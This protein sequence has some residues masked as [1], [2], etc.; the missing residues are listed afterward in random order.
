M[1][2]I[3]IV[4]I[5]TL[6]SLNAAAQKTHHSVEGRVVESFS[7]DNMGGVAVE[8]LNEDSV[9]IDTTMT[10]EIPKEIL[11]QEPTLAYVQGSYSFVV[12]KPGRYIIRVSKDGYETAC[13]DFVIHSKRE[14]HVA[15][16]DI[17][18][19]RSVMS[20]PEVDVVATKIKMVYKGDT[21][22]YNADA[23]RVAEGSML[24]ALIAMLP[25]ASIDANGQISVNGLPIESLLVNG[26]DFF[27]GS[28]KLA[29]Q[30]LP[31]YSVS[32][33]KIYNREGPTSRM[34]GRDMGD[35]DH[36][37]DVRL[38]KEYA[39]GYMANGEAGG[40]TKQ[41]YKLRAFGMRHNKINRTIAFA[42]INNLNDNRR[43]GDN[44]NW[45]SGA[46]PSGVLTTKSAGLSHMHTFGQFSNFIT[47]N[48]YT[49]TDNN[50]T[51]RSD[52]RTFL[53]GGDVMRQ[54]TADNTAMA[55]DFRSMNSFRIEGEGNYIQ[56]RVNASYTKR[57]NTGLA[58]SETGD[59]TSIANTLLNRSAASG[60]TLNINT[61]I[62]G[63]KKLYIDM[64]EL[65]AA[66]AY[67]RTVMDEF[68]LYDMRFGNGQ[69]PSFHNR[70]KD[71]SRHNMST[72]AKLQYNYILGSKTLKPYYN[73]KYRYN[74][75]NNMMY[76]LDLLDYAGSTD[77]GILPSTSDMLA[78][79]IESNNSYNYRER[80]FDHT[81]GLRLEWNFRKKGIGS[82]TLNMPVRWTT[83][84]LKGFRLE[85]LDIHRTATFFEPDFIIAMAKDPNTMFTQIRL[86]YLSETPQMQMMVDCA[87]NS[88]PLFIQ[89]GNPHLKN[90]HHLTASASLRHHWNTKSRID[91]GLSYMLTKNAVAYGFVYNRQDGITTIRPENVNGNW[92]IG[93]NATYSMNIGK[94]T[95]LSNAFS[96]M[97]IHSVDLASAEGSDV[98]DRSSVNNL[99]MANTLK[100]DTEF[101]NGWTMGLNAKVR[102]NN[103]TSERTGFSKVNATDFSFGMNAMINLPW[104]MQLT[105]DINQYFHRGYE[106]S[107][108]NTEE[109]VWNARL[110][111]SV[112]KGRLLFAIEGFDILG[113]L[114]S[115]RCHINSQGRTE[116]WTNTIPRYAMLSVTFNLT[117]K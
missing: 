52:T 86:S 25:G 46:L 53:E 37:M 90:I 56:G 2:R 81:A 109:L 36:V 110:T 117:K 77:F 24:D 113:K 67:E 54:S 12:N 59:E 70:Y 112:M 89:T 63:A 29:L 39:T 18:I 44:G 17:R 94:K 64:L 69:Q 23:F 107:G 4:F 105:T 49:R 93:G 80:T 8:L 104:K 87:D 83:K 34:M 97:F 102:W 5:L 65:D 73:I 38:K 48:T 33:I 98:S 58:T 85:N 82:L 40:G 79:A 51:S 32:K 100:M 99:N 26:Q 30:N 116:T 95:T 114:S 50:N 10:V 62:H 84:R 88:N 55:E 20:L 3:Y 61:S 92:R 21:L 103:A 68:G 13:T 14:R 57:R 60:N 19:M 76:R 106:M 115:R 42:N 41:R 78:D 91:A 43:I 47:N 9:L 15:V 101:S 27:N 66:F 75:T 22:V 31:A 45:Q 71:N 108:M 111:K 7:G 74:R 16:K 6:L 35:S 11:E 96:T 28:P 72:E 1:H